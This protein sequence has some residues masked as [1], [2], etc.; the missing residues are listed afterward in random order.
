[1]NARYA[2]GACNAV[3]GDARKDGSSRGRI[4]ENHRPSVVE[5]RAARQCE[6]TDR[7]RQKAAESE[8]KRN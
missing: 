4:G 6:K 8:R 5:L 2:R 1:M 7:K 3:A